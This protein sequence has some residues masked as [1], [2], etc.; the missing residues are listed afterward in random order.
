MIQTLNSLNNSLSVFS[1][2]IRYLKKSTINTYCVEDL[3]IQ[4]AIEILKTLKVEVVVQ[5]EVARDPSVLFVGNHISYVDI[6][7]LMAHIEKV[8]F[9]AKKE[10]SAWPVF[11]EAAK[12]V[13]TVFV[14]RENKKSRQSAR[15]S[16]KDAIRH[17][18]RIVVFPSGTTSMYENKRWKKGVFD[19][20]QQENCFI[21][22][23]RINYSPL[24]KVAYIDN[25]FFP[26]HLYKLC[27]TDAV[28]AHLE[29]HPPIKVEDAMTDAVYWNYW[30]K[31]LVDAKNN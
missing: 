18:K 1:D 19:I 12:K 31:G 26:V 10:I 27:R 7:L 9:V 24:R 17:G 29:F 21:Q 11:G 30:S 22:P 28:R 16:I 2:T 3:K 25:D 14:D 4:W 8:S 15:D 23:F 5:G 20:A 6:P 13:N